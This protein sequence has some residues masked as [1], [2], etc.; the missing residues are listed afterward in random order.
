M[1]AWARAGAALGV[2]EVRLGAVGEAQQ[3]MIILSVP[4]FRQETCDTC[5]PAC[6]RM[7]LAF[8]FPPPP[9]PEARLARRCRCIPGDGALVEAVY[10]TACY[11]KLDAQ[12]LDNT[13][14]ETDVA[15]ALAAGCPVLA[16][17][18]LRLLPYYLLAQPPQA[19]HSVL[20]IGLDAQDVSLHDPDQWGGARRQVR[21]ANFFV[22]WTLEPYSA[23]RL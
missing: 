23:Y 3:S 10:H 22:G 19:W 11:Y 20:I 17:V 21:R 6:L 13:H 9:V 8:R 16:N 2:T 7:A 4:Y 12:W 14:I 18:Q 15:A 1:A 5:A